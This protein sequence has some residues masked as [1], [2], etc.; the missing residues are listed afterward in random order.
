MESTSAALFISIS[1]VIFGIS[2]YYFTTR[3]KER[4]EI[5]A[6]GLAP[7]HFK[8]QSNPLPFLLILGIISIGI[9][10][11][12]AAGVTISFFFPLQKLEIIIF[13]VFLSLGIA[14]ISSYV[15]LKQIQ[16]RG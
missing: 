6:R 7:D 3:H 14:L 1:L 10:L 12:I 8:G 13:C 4:M 15:L 2:Y 9:A 5:I 11:G 16:K